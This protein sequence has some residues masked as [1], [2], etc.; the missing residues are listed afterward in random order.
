MHGAFAGAPTGSANG[1]YTC[2]L[3]TKE[4]LKAR[5]LVRKALAASRA[6]D[7]ER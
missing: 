2:G 6:L 7:D 4:L 3:W 1:N 5:R